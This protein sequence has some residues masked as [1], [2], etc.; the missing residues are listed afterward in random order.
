VL[1]GGAGV[2]YD[3]ASSQFGSLVGLGSFPF[4]ALKLNFFGTFPLDS[5]TAAP[6]AITASSLANSPNVLTAIDPHLK[7]PYTLQW[8]VALEQELGSQQS[9]SASYVGSSGRRLLQAP[10]VFSPNPSFAEASLVGNTAT[11]D[12]NALQVQFQR[13]LSRGLQALAS[14]TWSHSID[15]GS[16]GSKS[17]DFG[18]EFVPALGAKA[19]RGP[20]DFDIRHAFSAG[21]TYEIPAPQGNRLTNAVLRRWSLQNFIIA[22]SAPPIDVFYSN[23]GELSNAEAYV[24]PDL[25][26]GQ[27]LYLFGAQCAATF[28]ASGALAPGQGCPGG[29]GFNPGAFA[30]PPVDANGVPLRQGNLGRNA[31]RGFGAAQWDF[32]VHREFAIREQLKLQFRAEMFNVLNHP[33][34]GQP[35]GN[36]QSP[37]NVGPSFG[38]SSL[39]LGQSLSGAQFAGNVGSGGLNPLYQIGGPRSIQFALKLSF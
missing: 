15:D 20:S 19:N 10:S 29:M 12:Y 23:F 6:P 32:A 21:V 13:R 39:M 34:F 30:S 38:V 1:R 16:A 2:F 35:S 24:R 22:F 18:N 31:L 17:S 8:N 27:P 4:G 14:Y 37:Q 5:A 9:L 25:I 7:L 3:L 26:P 11:S 33:N 28:Q 36:I